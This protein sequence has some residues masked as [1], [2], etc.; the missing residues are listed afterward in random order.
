M[1]LIELILARVERLEGV[2]IN[3]QER[4]RARGIIAAYRFKTQAPK[5][6]KHGWFIENLK[7]ELILLI[8]IVLVVLTILG[9][10]ITGLRIL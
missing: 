1:Q 3:E 6:A 9:V 10:D 7:L 5:K 2:S 8:L 4:Q